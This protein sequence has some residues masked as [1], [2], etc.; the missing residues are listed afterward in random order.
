M[1]VGAQAIYLHTAS[2]EFTVDETTKDSDLAIDTRALRS[3]PKL[4]EA[5]TK[6]GFHRDVTQPGSWLSDDGIPVD[7]MVPEALSGTG[8]RRGARIPPHSSKAA[9]R[10]P[11]LE[12]AVVDNEPMPIHSYDPT[13]PRQATVKV[14]GPAALL[15]AKL[16]KLGERASQ[17]HRL[18]DKDAHDIYRLLVAT[19]TA[20]LARRCEC[21]D[22]RR[23]RRRCYRAPRWTICAS[24]SAVRPRSAR[25]WLAVL[26]SSPATRPL[27]RPRRLSSR[28]TY[29]RQSDADRGAGLR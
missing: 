9:R 14:A 29:A 20:A 18:V 21:T 12:A 8:G 15:V 4:E 2:V 24:C 16:H 5:M 26:R 6:A 27:Q 10:T 22:G 17:P 3:T 28:K 11:G 19:E 7:L 1:L 13:D 25:R 23:N